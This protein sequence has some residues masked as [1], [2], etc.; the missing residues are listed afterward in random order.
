MSPVRAASRPAARRAAPKRRTVKTRSVWGRRLFALGILAGVVLMA[1]GFWKLFDVGDKVQSV[2]LPLK[3]EDIIRAEADD[4]DIAHTVEGDIELPPID[5]ALIAGVIYQE[6]KFVDQTSSAG[7][8]G[9][10]QITPDTAETIENLSGGSTFTF[11]DL[12]DPELNIRYGTYYLR[13]LMNKYGGDEVAVLAAYNAGEGNADAWGGADMS[14]SDIEFPETRAY[15]DEVLEKRDQYAKNYG[16]SINL[17]IPCSDAACG[18]DIQI[19]QFRG[20]FSGGANSNRGYPYNGAGPHMRVPF[21]A[22]LSNPDATQANLAIAVGGATIW[23]SSVELRF[24]IA[25]KLGMTLF[26]DGSNV[27]YHLGDFFKSF[28]APHLS[29]GIGIRYQTPV[30][31]LRADFGVRIPCL[32]VLNVPNPCRPIYDPGLETQIP[33]ATPAD[34]AKYLSP[35]YGEA[36]TVFRIP[37]A[38][39]IAIGEAY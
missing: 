20:F 18:S 22:G 4:P 12:A 37:L 32:Q 30:G 17:N 15:V 33:A 38:V 24:P 7:A 5:P 23:E 11:E 9:L 31:P 2:I 1:V 27:G 26:V 8:R 16:E 28:G 21:L 39:S 25:D 6:S 36:G 29:A 3:H 13:Y 10:M 34:I 14:R 19:L 35:V